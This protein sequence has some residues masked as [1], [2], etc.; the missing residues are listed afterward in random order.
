[1]RIGPGVPGMFALGVLLG[2]L[3]ARLPAATYT[4][5]ST[6]N[7]GAGTLRTA[8]TN[9]N[10]NPGTDL[11]VFNISGTG[12]F[13]INLTTPLPPIIEPVILDAT[14]QPG[15]AGMPRVLI[16]GASAGDDTSGF[17]I[18]TSNCVIKG[19]AIGRFGKEAIRIEGTGGNVV[20][21]CFIGTGHFGTNAL[22]NGWGSAGFGGITVLSANN[23]IGGTEA[24]NRNLIS[25]SNLHGIFVIGGAA[26]SNRIV[27]NYI[28]TDVTGTKRLG[29]IQNGISISGA[30]FT[31]VGDGT[32]AGRNVIS[33]NNQSGVYVLG[34]PV[35][36]IHSL[37]NIIQGNYIGTD[38]TG[39]VAVSNAAD[40][41]TLSGASY[42]LV[43]GTNAG[44]RNVISGN[45]GR[46][47]MIDANGATGNVI[48]GNYIGTDASGAARLGNSYGGVEI[49]NASSNLVGGAVSGARNVISANGLSGVTINDASATANLVQ[50]NFIGTDWTGSNALG[51]L[52]NGVF[53]AGVTNNLIGGPNAGEGNV[54]SGNAQNGILLQDATCRNNVIQGN[55]IGTDASGA[56]RVGNGFAGIRI[57][58]PAQQVGGVVAGAR[59][60]ISGNTNSGIYL[61][62]PGA[63]NN[64]IEGNFI[65]TTASGAAALGNGY[66]GI[67]VENAPG[68]QIGGTSSG[69]RNLVSGN[70][71]NGIIVQFVGASNNVIQGNYIGT[72]V[73]GTAAVPNGANLS[74]PGTAIAGGVDI[75]GAPNNLIGGVEAGAGNLISGNWRDGVCIGDAGATNNRV[76]GNLIGTK[77]DGV[78]PLSNETHNVDIRVPGGAHNNLVGGESPGAGNVI[79]HVGSPGPGYDGVRVRDGNVGNLIRGNSFFGNALSSTALAIDLGVNGVTANDNCDGDTGANQLQNFPV[80]TNAQSAGGVTRI[81]GTLNSTPGGSFLVQFY[82]SPTPAHSGYGEGQV[83]LG[84]TNVATDASCNGAFTALL[85]VAVSPGWFVSATA[86]DAANNTSEFGPNVVVTAAQLPA[87]NAQPQSQT[88]PYG[89]NATFSVTATGTPPLAYQWRFHGTNLPGATTSVLV[90]SNVT[91]AQAGAYDVVVSNPFG[92]THSAVATLTVLVSPPTLSIQK[93]AGGQVLL[94]WSA[95]GPPFALQVTTNL[96]PPVVWTA[97]TNV[98]VLTNNQYI[99][100]VP[101]GIGNRFYRLVLP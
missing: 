23:L 89:S 99:V 75:A 64:V 58:S 45:G 96:N 85:P 79:A 43:G 48:V 92:A 88:V 8:I 42:T 29:N 20:Q 59:N 50:G 57:E 80:V 77:A 39:A 1:M 72:D 18:Q 31:L 26:V 78:S 22:G 95:Q 25:G 14:T 12:P 98:P 36:F 82:A 6:G 74:P 84:A 44:A 101:A 10:A 34:N 28:G 81:Q 60:V 86:T 41:I 52:R 97:A 61:F 46:G 93:E 21:G 62:G 19:L 87:I 90:R 69:A 40:G 49:L 65:G 5:T 54:I 53:I 30:R 27:G 35:L 33:G 51:N 66:A 70:A 7:A 3:G 32:A 13:T 73:T 71:L 9:A 16:N 2:L 56:R 47:V 68:N 94:A 38:V 100:T 4:V 91:L 83:F 15:Y 55:L 11:I 76:Q 63:S 17:Y 24:T 67:N 37:S